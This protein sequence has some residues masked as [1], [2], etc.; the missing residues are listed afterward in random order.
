[1]LFLFKLNPE[2]DRNPELN[3]TR[4]QGNFSIDSI[5][6]C[7]KVK[8][9]YDYYRVVSAGQFGFDCR[10]YCGRRRHM[11]GGARKKNPVSGSIVRMRES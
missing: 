5:F 1:M 10:S 4:G 7:C 6:V 9:Y 11:Q 2:I 8:G 3:I